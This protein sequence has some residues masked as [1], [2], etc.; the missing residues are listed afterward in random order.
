MI[1]TTAGRSKEFILRITAVTMADLLVSKPVATSDDL[2]AHGFKP[3]S[4]DY[5]RLLRSEEDAKRGKHRP[6]RESFAHLR[7]RHDD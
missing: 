4:F 6:L 7:A 3:E 1:R 5:P 2:A